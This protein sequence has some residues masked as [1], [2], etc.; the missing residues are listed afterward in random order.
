MEWL[1]P[2]AIEDATPGPMN[3][4]I[5]IV[6]AGH[7]GL[8]CAAALRQQGFDGP[9]HL[10]TGEPSLPYQ[11]P[12]LSKAYLLGKSSATDLQFRPERFYAEQQVTLV[13]GQVESIDR[14]Q[15]HVALQD[16]RTLPYGHLVLATGSSPRRLDVPGASL[17]GVLSLQTLADADRLLPLLRRA[18][19]AVVI[20]AGFIGLEFASVARSLGVAVEVLDVADRPMAR[21]LSP[22]CSQAFDAAHRAQGTRLRFGTGVARF[23]GVDGKV[24]AAITSDGERIPADLVL[25]GIGAVPRTALA[26]AAGLELEN[27]IR[28]DAMLRTSDPRISAIGDVAAFPEPASGR[29]VRLESVQNAT[30]QARLVAA[31]LVGKEAPYQAVP[32]FWSDQ[33]G[34]KL[35]IAGLRRGD[36]QQVVLGDPAERNFTVLCLR[37]DRL[38]AVETVNRPADHMLARRLLAQPCQV[39][40]AQARA[41]G[42]TLKSLV[43]QPEGAK[44]S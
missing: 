42:F 16:G 39:T 1:I 38:A 3:T 41:P 33:A 11:R 2:Y 12:P 4:P 32:W 22:E 18:R 34:F 9:L 13:S 40:Q 43:P 31:R 44:A 24:A 30:D 5:V 28:V 10:I 36:E 23:D 37:G 6:G 7:G 8:N 27:G 17:E 19:T 25:V 14:A 26:A 15:R 20:G 35:Q 21:A 29:L